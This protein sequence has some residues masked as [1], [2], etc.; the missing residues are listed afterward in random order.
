M[1]KILFFTTLTILGLVLICGCVNQ[2]QP[3]FQ[4]SVV[5]SAP[6]QTQ[7][8]SDFTSCKSPESWIQ[9]K[10]PYDG[11]TQNTAESVKNILLHRLRVSK[12]QCGAVSFIPENEKVVKSARVE[13]SGL[14]LETAKLIIGKPGKFELKIETN[15]SMYEQILTNADISEVV[16]QYNEYQDGHYFISIELTEAGAKKLQWAL[17]NYGAILDRYHHN[18]SLIVDGDVIF[19]GP[20]SEDFAAGVVKEPP[21]TIIPMSVGSMD[22]AVQLSGRLSKG[23]LLVDVIIEDSG[24]LNP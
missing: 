6:A 5:A 24:S 10:F 9:I 7:N 16:Y 22:K 13:F 20:I 17:K 2:S 23:P 14:D 12:A 11:I 15:A 19:N 1:K 21:L 4:K 3:S 8:T 18:L